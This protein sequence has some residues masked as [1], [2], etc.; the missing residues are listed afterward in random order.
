MDKKVYY[1]K[2]KVEMMGV[3]N[4]LESEGIRC[5]E[6]DKVDSSYGGV[7]GDYQLMVDES[8]EEKAKALIEKFES[9]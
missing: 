5:Y 8:D 3:K 1:T 4:L 7:F 9:E 6:V 2:S